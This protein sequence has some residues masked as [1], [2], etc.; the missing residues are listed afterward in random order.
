MN[1]KQIFPPLLLPVLLLLALLLNDRVARSQFFD[2]HNAYLPLIMNLP[3]FTPT[4]TVTNTPPVIQPTVTS[5][6][7]SQPTPGVTVSPPPSTSGNVTITDIFYDGAGSIEPDEYVEFKNVDNKVI[8]LQGWTLR[9]NQNHV[10]VF[11]AFLMQ[12]NQVCRVYTN[13]IHPNYC[14]FSYGS[15]SAIWNNTGDCASLRN[16]Q[17]YEIS[18]RCY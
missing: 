3:N 18:K 1:K 4:P 2:D 9:D 8:Q 14:G 7:V 10:F 5:T 15:G 13:Q 11:P 12:P 17:G 16:S 6:Q